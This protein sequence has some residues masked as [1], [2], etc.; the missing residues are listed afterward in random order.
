MTNNIHIFVS[1]FVHFSSNNYHPI[2][3][4]SIHL[5]RH[6]IVPIHPSTSYSYKSI[7]V[8]IYKSKSNKLFKV[9][10]QPL[11]PISFFFFI[12]KLHA[13]FSKVDIKK[14]FLLFLS[15]V[16]ANNVNS[17]FVQFFFLPRSPCI[18]DLLQ[19]YARRYVVLLYVITMG[20]YTCKR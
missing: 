4:G 17:R 18:F 1:Y 2:S 7:G 20:Y 11:L 3:S 13:Q 12:L 19:F 14:N 5:H 15:L 9:D 6:G 8:H 10:A 16:L